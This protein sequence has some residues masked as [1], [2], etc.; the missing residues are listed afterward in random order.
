MLSHDLF[1]VSVVYTILII[2]VFHDDGDVSSEA[3][4]YD[5]RHFAAEIFFDIRVAVMCRGII[6]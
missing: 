6:R 3:V 2:E 4:L 1:K 5:S